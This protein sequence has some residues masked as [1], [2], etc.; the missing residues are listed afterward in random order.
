MES[1]YFA[2]ADTVFIDNLGLSVFIQLL[3]YQGLKKITCLNGV[4]PSHRIYRLLLKIRGVEVVD[5]DFF[6]GHLKTQDGESIYFKARRIAGIAALVAS[7]RIVASDA[8]LDHLNSN[9]GSNTIRLFI[10]KQLARHIEYWTS[11]AFVAF[12]ISKETNPVVWLKKPVRFPEESLLELIPEVRLKFYSVHFQHELDFFKTLFLDLLRFC[13]QVVFGYLDRR[14]LPKK[15]KSGVLMLQEE[16][17][18]SQNVLRN[19]LSWLDLEG[20][21]NEFE[22]YVLKS[23]SLLETESRIESALGEKGVTLL[24]FTALGIAWHSIKKDKVLVE[25]RRERVRAYLATLKAS[26]PATRFFLA[27]VGFILWQSELMGAISKALSIRVFVTKEPYSVYADAIQLCAERIGIQ[28]I[29]IQYSNMGFVSPGMMTTADQFLIFSEMYKQVF[30]FPGIE[31]IEFVRVGYLYDGVAELVRARAAAHRSKLHAKGANFIVCYFDESVQHDRWGLVSKEDHLAEL[32]CLA[33]KV[34]TDRSFGVVIK[35]QYIK[36]SPSMLYPDDELIQKA[37]AT[38]RYLELKEGNHRNDIYP[39]EAAMASDIC[40]GHKFGATAALEAA[41]SGIRTV[42]LDS[43]GTKTEWD[44]L[45]GSVNIEFVNIEQAVEAIS[46]YR[47]G[48]A[49]QQDLGDW[50][51]IISHFVY[52]HESNAR[53]VIRDLIAGHTLSLPDETIA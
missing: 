4:K 52:R 15:M 45:Y 26:T 36:N 48:D 40:I 32:N 44:S 18:R 13:K 51:K 8:M 3:H 41:I 28:T 25:L 34:L 5:A 24:P 30:S 12:A 1:R 7:Q 38:G 39:A 27:K 46:Q 17:I 43:Y 29:A 10:A 19:Q 35:S 20:E 33:L 6:T 16:T 49:T 21:Q 14:S 53:L 31:P 47:K 42:I 37:H 11:R 22:T 9:Y 2:E 23:P 50:T